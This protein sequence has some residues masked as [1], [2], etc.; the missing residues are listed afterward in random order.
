MFRFTL[1]VKP[2]RDIEEKL[3]EADVFMTDSHEE[4]E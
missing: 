4:E 2:V 3:K 1:P